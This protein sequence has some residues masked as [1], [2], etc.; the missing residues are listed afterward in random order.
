M[1]LWFQIFSVWLSCNRLSDDS[2]ADAVSDGSIDTSFIEYKST[3]RTNFTIR[4]PLDTF[5]YE[6]PILL[7][8]CSMQSGEPRFVPKS[9]SFHSKSLLQSCQ[10]SPD[11]NSESVRRPSNRLIHWYRSSNQFK[12]IT[13][14]E[15]AHV[16]QND[17]LKA[18]E[19]FY[20]FTL[21]D[22]KTI[23]LPIVSVNHCLPPTTN[24]LSRYRLHTYM[25]L[26][27]TLHV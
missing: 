10:Q 14:P 23:L 11:H 18:F 24:H 7:T 21:S 1:L 8:P 25:L 27:R 4:M 20:L 6:Y 19:I 12:E 17:I 26:T 16:K 2:T 3:L 5:Y 15:V 13:M 22:F 9:K